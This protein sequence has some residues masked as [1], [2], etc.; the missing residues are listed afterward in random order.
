MQISKVAKFPNVRLPAHC[1]FIVNLHMNHKIC[2][3]E[4]QLCTKGAPDWS[5]LV[6]CFRV[7]IKFPYVCEDFLTKT[8]FIRWR[9]IRFQMSQKL[10]F[11]IKVI[12]ANCTSVRPLLVVNSQ[13]LNK[14]LLHTKFFFAYCAPELLGS[15]GDMRHYVRSK[16]ASRFESFIALE[17]AISRPWNESWLAWA[18]L[19]C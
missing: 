18:K 16:C 12:T 13:V 14:I 15:I 11:E 6:V 19:S 4:E 5:R 10:T 7:S 8:T 1:V 17:A 9:F 3:A 2:H